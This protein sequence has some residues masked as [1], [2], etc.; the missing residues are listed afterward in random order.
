MDRERIEALAQII[1]IHA[2]ADDEV[3][4][5]L[6]KMLDHDNAQRA[7]LA[8]KNT[9]IA[10]LQAMADQL[11]AVLMGNDPEYSTLKATLAE[12]EAPSRP[13]EAAGGEGMTRRKELE[14]RARKVADGVI[15]CPDGLEVKVVLDAL[16]QV[17]R[18]CWQRAEEKI[19]QL[20]EKENEST[21]DQIWE[22][23]DWCR[24]QKEGY[25]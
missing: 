5:S 9:E 17:E 4:H 6:S 21:D 10:E 24:A 19:E 16:T 18:E 7:A 1:I 20:M 12:I 15:D 22:Y 2:G 14:E 11:D 13:G 25:E 8:E 23:R 3:A